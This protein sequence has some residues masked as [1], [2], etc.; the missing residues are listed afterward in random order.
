LV[1]TRLTP[2]PKELAD[3]RSIAEW[4]THHSGQTALC[5]QL[6]NLEHNLRSQGRLRGLEYCAAAT[7]TGARVRKSN[8]FGTVSSKSCMKP[9][10]VEEC[11][12][13]A[14]VDSWAAAGSVEA[15]AKS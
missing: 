12:M 15:K 7:R 13:T 9:P 3:R 14:C 2:C 8:F 10:A 1:F 5:A 6:D 11:A 4:E